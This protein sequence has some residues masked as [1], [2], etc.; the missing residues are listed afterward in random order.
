M[1]YLYTYELHHQ[2]FF[3]D[4][5]LSGTFPLVVAFRK[6]VHSNR[7]RVKN[8]RPGYTMNINQGGE[9]KMPEHKISPLCQ[10]TPSCI[11]RHS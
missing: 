9:A 8:T 7:D 11:E 5:I 4:S 6:R 2:L 1:T 10:Y 3:L